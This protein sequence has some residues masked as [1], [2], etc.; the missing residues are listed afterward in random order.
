[1]PLLAW[2]ERKE[3]EKFHHNRDL[4]SVLMD[5]FDHTGCTFLKDRLITNIV[6]F[7]GSDAFSGLESG[8]TPIGGS[9]PNVRDRQFLENAI[10]WEPIVKKYRSLRVETPE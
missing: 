6:M 8:A 10:K 5:I 2:L 7:V 9:T 4:V 1:M 3:T